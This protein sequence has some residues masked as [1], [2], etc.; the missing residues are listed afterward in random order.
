MAFDLER[1]AWSCR[2]AGASSKGHAR[3]VEKNTKWRG[4]RRRS[5]YG[6]GRPTRSPGAGR[7]ARSG[8]RTR[9]PARRPSPTR[10]PTSTRFWR[11]STRSP[12][13]PTAGATC[14]RA[15]R[16]SA[17]PPTRTPG[18][19]G[20]SSGTAP[21]GAVGSRPTF[22]TARRCPSGRPVVTC[23]TDATA[24]GGQG[25]SSGRPSTATTG[26]V[27]T[28]FPAGAVAT[29]TGATTTGSSPATTPTPSAV[30]RPTSRSSPSTGGTATSSPSSAGGVA[31]TG[32]ASP[33]KT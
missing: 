16:P 18:L 30:S 7:V 33:G 22:R 2:F 24:L 8:L 29:S 25:G 1:R 5:A 27:P 23:A 32:L 12:T 21:T 20:P 4:C 15:G 26:A 10:T 31:A 19:A 28:A 3:D 17:S 14:G 6:V 13:G 11:T 9:V